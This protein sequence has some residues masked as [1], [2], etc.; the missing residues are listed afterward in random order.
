MSYTYSD[1]FEK[2][3]A[4][5]KKMAEILPDK[6]EKYLREMNNKKQN[7]KP[8]LNKSDKYGQYEKVCSVI[9]GYKSRNEVEDFISICEKNAC[10]PEIVD[11][12]FRVELGMGVSSLSHWTTREVPPSSF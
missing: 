1:R 2:E 8:K 4:R 3:L 11:E 5:V 6:G 7:M 12:I 10:D 9:L